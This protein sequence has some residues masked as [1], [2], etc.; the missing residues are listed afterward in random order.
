LSQTYPHPHEDSD[1]EK[2]V[3]FDGT[4]GVRDFSPHGDGDEDAFLDTE[5]P[6]VISV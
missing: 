1:G 2:K 3:S 4:G 5:F 6:V